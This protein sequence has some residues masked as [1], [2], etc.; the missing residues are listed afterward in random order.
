MRRPELRDLL[1][2]PTA[3][4]P[5]GPISG[6]RLPACDV[7]GWDLAGRPRTL[8]LASPGRWALLL[9][10][11]SHCDG[12]LPFWEVPR[13]PAR[14]GL[15]PEDMAVVVTRGPD[16]EEPSA[17][18]ALVGGDPVAASDPAL[19]LMSGAAWRT[20]RVLGPPFFVLVDGEQVVTEGVAWSVE[21]VAADVV[22][23]R[24]PAASPAAP[25]GLA[26]PAGP[27]AP[28]GLAPRVRR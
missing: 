1:A 24:C 9:F 15:E 13:A 8:R 22:R 17:L 23:V 28:A 6:S 20:Y 7:D 16:D 21:Q 10:L 14:C 11:G 19:L 12:C 4:T 18:T 5:D 27:G 25:A 3:I 26:A 2:V